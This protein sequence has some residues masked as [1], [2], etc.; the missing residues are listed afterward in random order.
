MDESEQNE[1]KGSF[2]LKK[3]FFYQQLKWKK[4]LTKFCIQLNRIYSYLLVFSGTIQ[5]FILFNKNPQIFQ[6]YII[7]NEMSRYKV[8]L[9]SN[10]IQFCNLP[11]SLSI[12][13]KVF[14]QI[15]V[16]FIL[17]NFGNIGL[18]NFEG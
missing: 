16:S 12:F 10:F 2:M 7:V 18:G 15:L 13:S 17:F 6:N 3:V 4:Y 11:L 8:W 5:H 14:G 9:S 1:V